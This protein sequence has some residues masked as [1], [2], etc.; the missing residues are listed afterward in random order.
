[1]STA[2][3]AA[4]PVYRRRFLPRAAAPATAVAGGVVIAILA[5][6]AIFAPLIAP[7]DPNA[8]DLERSLAAVSWSHPFGQDA[9]GRDI[10]SRLIVGTRSSLLGPL[11]VVAG[12]TLIGVPLGLLAGFA[13]GIV[14]GVLARAWDLM[15]AFPGLLLAIAVVAMFG[16]GFKTATLAVLVGYI[17]L[18]ARVVRGV[19]LVER[20]K[21]YVDALRIQGFGGARI[22]VAHILPNT[23]GTIVAQ[24]TLNFGY[25][26]LDLGGLAF[27]GLGVRAPQA[28]WGAMLAEG[29]HS[30]LFAVNE[31]LAASIMIAV[32][33]VAFN[34]LGDALTQRF[35]RVR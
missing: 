26:L 5:V 22:A 32:A 2:E 10:L 20:S 17:P 3:V 19:V 34:L 21:T 12:S 13:G 9:L 16:P 27:L 14:D 6:V 29:R 23:S 18:M 33:V 1:M 4:A 25:A 8:V 30:I 35:A 15:F 11:I 24:A 7:H 31:V 28:D